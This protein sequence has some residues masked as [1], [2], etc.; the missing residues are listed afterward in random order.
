M[1]PSGDPQGLGGLVVLEPGDVDSDERIP[2][3]RRKRRDRLV[4]DPPLGD[5]MRLPREH[6]LE[7]GDLVVG[8]KRGPATSASVVADE[9]IAQ[10]AQ[11]VA[12]V[13]VVPGG[14]VAATAPERRCPEPC[15]PRVPGEPQYASAAR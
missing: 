3:L 15:L 12:E 2:E 9:G 4:H 14:T 7:V 5:L 1:V 13:V 8:C 10:D 11:Q 6:V